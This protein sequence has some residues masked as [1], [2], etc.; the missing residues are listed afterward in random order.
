MRDE[1][2]QLMKILL[3]EDDSLDRASL[4]RALRNHNHGLYITEATSL[5][6][7]CAQLEQHHF[8]V[9]LSEYQ[10][11]DGN[12]ATLLAQIHAM[13]G[14][15]PAV[16]I[17]GSYGDDTLAEQCIHI[18]AQAYII[19][20]D[21]RPHSLFSTIVQSI[22][23]ARQR[24]EHEAEAAMLRV[25]AE[26][27]ALTGLYNRHVFDE[28]LRSCLAQSERYGRSFALLMIDLDRFKQ[29]NDTWGH[30]T[31]DNLLQEVAHRLRAITRDSDR[32]CR[33]G[34]DEFAIL[35]PEI[36]DQR[37]PAIL[38]ERLA[39]ALLDPVCACDV[40]IH[41]TVSI[42]VAIYPDHGTTA[43]MLLSN[44]DKAMYRCKHREVPAGSIHSTVHIWPSTPA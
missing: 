5:V 13:P 33:I 24:E 9:V 12:A 43:D 7:A 8:D 41:V 16:I 4:M 27:D 25:Q 36:I 40:D 23:H 22:E 32:V 39:E 26:H 2:S 6:A 1:T 18:G 15:R 21:I 35:L 20:E 19:K 11:Q 38:A 28:S 30:C 14:T 42:G 17:I 10:L 37:Q 44:A 34:G 31:G 3:V 29:I